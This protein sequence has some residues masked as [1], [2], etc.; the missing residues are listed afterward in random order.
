M[1]KRDAQSPAACVT[2][3]AEIQKVISSFEF[4]NSISSTRICNAFRVFDPRLTSLM[5]AA[6]YELY[7]SGVGSPRLTQINGR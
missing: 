2:A 7:V 6:E 5:L 3:C 4:E 1:Q